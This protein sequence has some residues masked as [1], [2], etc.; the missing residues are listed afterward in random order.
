MLTIDPELEMALKALAMQEHISPNEI[1]K[2][3]ISHYVSQNQTKETQ[4]KQA[5][6]PLMAKVPNSVSLA[7]ELIRERRLEAKHEQDNG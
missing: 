7:D 2:R 1:I 4:A 6:M 3:L 5:L